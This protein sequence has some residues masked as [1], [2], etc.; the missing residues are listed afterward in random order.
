MTMA[1][2]SFGFV[3]KVFI[4]LREVQEVNCLVEFFNFECIIA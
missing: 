4:G 1:R 3:R 2:F